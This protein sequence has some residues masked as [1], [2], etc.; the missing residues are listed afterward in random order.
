MVVKEL[1]QF[2]ISIVKSH[3]KQE[4]IDRIKYFWNT[5][6]TVAQWVMMGKIQM[7]FEELTVTAHFA[8][9]VS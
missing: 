8:N 3:N 4:L 6:L 2:L 5:K 9:F 1:K 7:K